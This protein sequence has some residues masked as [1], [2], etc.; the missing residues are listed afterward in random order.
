VR[1]SL[2]DGVDEA[3]NILERLANVGIDLAQVTQDLEIEGVQAFVK[4]YE[5]L[6]ETIRNVKA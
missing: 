6:I 1:A 4:S 3:R 5:S 2:A